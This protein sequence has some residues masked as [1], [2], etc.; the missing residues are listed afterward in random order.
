[1]HYQVGWGGVFQESLAFNL[2]VA[3]NTK[4]SQHSAL[5]LSGDEGCHGQHVHKYQP[6]VTAIEAVFSPILSGVCVCV[7]V[8]ACICMYAHVHAHVPCML[9]VLVSIVQ[10]KPSHWNLGR[11]LRGT[12][13]D[14]SEDLSIL[15]S[16]VHWKQNKGSQERKGSRDWA[17]GLECS[18]VGETIGLVED[19]FP[20]LTFWGSSFILKQ[21]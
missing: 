8:H 6:E 19:L 10:S 20:A 17:G 4:C 21:N 1:M 11:C 12:H 2:P 15:L 5:S 14:Y 9:S 3:Q 16:C 7:S 13:C 18:E